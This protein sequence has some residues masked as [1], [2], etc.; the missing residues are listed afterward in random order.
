METMFMINGILL[1]AAAVV[2]WPMCRRMHK[3]DM[4][5]EKAN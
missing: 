1:L 5:L 2:F 4:A 3:E